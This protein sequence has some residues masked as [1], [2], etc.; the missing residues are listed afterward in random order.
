MISCDSFDIL[1]YVYKSISFILTERADAAKAR[2]ED[3]L[4]VAELVVGALNSTRLAQSAAEEAISRA[5]NDISATE[6]DLTQIADETRAAARRANASSVEVEELEGRVTAVK[7]HYKINQRHLE[8][9][10][11]AV[12]QAGLQ[13]QKASNDARQLEDVRG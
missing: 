3:T 5:T 11:L 7:Q 6:E 9:T 2:A 13:A 4:G 8:D 10:R 1:L 12:N